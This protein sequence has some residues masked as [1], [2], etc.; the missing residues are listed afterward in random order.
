ME[1]P[2]AG[3][4]SCKDVLLGG[5]GDKHCLVHAAGQNLCLLAQVVLHTTCVPVGLS[6]VLGG[7]SL[8]FWSPFPFTLG[9]TFNHFSMK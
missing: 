9:N 7:S 5:P 2:C 1:G 8:T 3:V 6:L 4:F